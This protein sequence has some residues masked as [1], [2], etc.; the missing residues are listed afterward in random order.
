MEHEETEM[1][2]DLAVQHGVGCWELVIF[3]LF[4]KNETRGQGLDFKGLGLLVEV[5]ISPGIS[6]RDPC[7]NK[8]LPAVDS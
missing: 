1:E 2:E 6:M 5:G 3:K 7:F 8:E 4:R